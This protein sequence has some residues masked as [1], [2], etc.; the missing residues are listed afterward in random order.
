MDSILP[1]VNIAKIVSPYKT[2]VVGF[3]G[4]VYNGKEFNHAGLHA[5]NEMKKQGKNIILLSNS[6]ERIFSV[7]QLMKKHQV[8]PSVFSLIMTAGEMMH[9]LFFCNSKR[10]QLR[11]KKY[12]RLGFPIERPILSG[13]GFEQV[14]DINNADF[15]FVGRLNHCGES[16]QQYHEVLECS[17]ALN[18]PMVCV[19]NDV[20]SYINGEIC[21]GSG[22][23]AEQY[24]M[25]GGKIH[26]LGKPDIHVL[27]YVL[28][29][30]P[31]KPEDLL[32]IG[33]S[34]PTDIKMANLYGA[35]SVLVTGGVHKDSLGE[36]YIP[37][38]QK[39]KD[40]CGDYGAYPKYL[41]SELRW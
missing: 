1:T 26:T 6:A 5:L 16:V 18:L 17:A 27:K 40:L 39:A 23:F 36:G 24:A 20:A 3:F 8:S 34:L 19:G 38:L 7:L 29:D 9:S 21:D 15:I 4:V 41:I 33:D 32:I 31:T 30:F 12:F 2:V 37:D 11:G 25:M 28:E 22:L 35:D 13:L 10:I 14:E